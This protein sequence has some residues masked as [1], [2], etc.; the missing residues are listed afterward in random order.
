MF[1]VNND[2]PS[3]NHDFSKLET[4]YKVEYTIDQRATINEW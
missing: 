3:K 4:K 1:H 2:Q